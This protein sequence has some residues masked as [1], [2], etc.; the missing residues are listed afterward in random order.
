MWTP[1]EA[2]AAAGLKGPHDFCTFVSNIAATYM[3]REEGPQWDEDNWESDKDGWNSIAANTVSSVFDGSLGWA[4]YQMT[5][6]F[7][8]ETEDD[9]D[10]TC[11]SYDKWPKPV[12]NSY[13]SLYL[14]VGD[15]GCDAVPYHTIYNVFVEGDVKRCIMDL[16]QADMGVID[17]RMD[18]L[19][20]GLLCIYWDNYDGYNPQPWS[21][22]DCGIQAL[23][24]NDYYYECYYEPEL[25]ICY[26]L[27][28]EY[29]FDGDGC[30]AEDENG[31]CTEYAC[32]YGYYG[33]E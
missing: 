2:E 26:G 19:F 27:T 8:L 11:S 33:F 15:R 25:D 3:M 20:D 21:Q 17:R 23:F 28:W 22:D 13:E 14:E 9:Y 29:D 6:I 18:N 10:L 32:Y 7:D 16:S 4:A 30:L 24:L 1:T 5:M 12:K 31:L